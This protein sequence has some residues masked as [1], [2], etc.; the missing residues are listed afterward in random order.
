MPERILITGAGGFLGSHICH[1][2]GSRGHSIAAVGR[3]A[4]TPASG[5][6]YPNL[7]KLGGMTLPDRALIALIEEFR[8][9]VLVHCAGTASVADSVREPYADFQRTA[10]VC[11]FTLEAVRKHA[12]ACRVVLLSSAAVYGNPPALPIHEESTVQPISP[13]GYH[14]RMCEMLAEEY[15]LIYGLD[16]AILRLF[17]AYGERL[18]KQVLF[19]LCRKFTAAD[20]DIV[21]I[22]GTGSETRDFIHAADV[23]QVVDCVIRERASGEFNVASGV[24]TSIRDIA[25]LVQA[26]LASPKQVTYT[27][28]SRAGDPLHWQ[29]DIGRITA[30][31]FSQKIQLTAGIRDYCRWFQSLTSEQ[32]FSG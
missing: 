25:F 15:A 9:T 7:W 26:N 6:L 32:E 16:V 8:P 3:F 11:A 19:D 12:P 20:A 1:Y 10:E 14:K 27:G 4:A 21:E 29:A 28:S 5:A 13:Y 30:L 22:Y 17:S 2:F 23:A 31:G 18:R 24:Q